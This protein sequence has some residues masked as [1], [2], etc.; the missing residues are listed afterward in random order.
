M[1]K[2]GFITDSDQGDAIADVKVDDDEAILYIQH[3]KNKINVYR[4]F[5]ASVTCHIIT[6]LTCF[7]ALTYR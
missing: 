6:P 4:I 7:R 5:T 1:K 3:S 2:N